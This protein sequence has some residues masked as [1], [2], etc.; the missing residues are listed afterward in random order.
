MSKWAAFRGKLLLENRDFNKKIGESGKEVQ[1]MAKTTEKEF[2]KTGESASDLAKNFAAIG[3]AAV[4]GGI[5][6][7]INRLKDLEAE[8]LQVQYAWTDMGEAGRKAVEKI[9]R[10]SSMLTGSATRDTAAVQIAL[11]NEGIRPDTPRG[12]AL[13]NV[14]SNFADATGRSH[15]STVD[16]LGASSIATGSA[17]GRL[18]D[19]FSAVSPRTRGGL[20]TGFD[21]LGQFLPALAP[22]GSALGLEDTDMA[23]LLGTASWHTPRPRRAGSGVRMILEEAVKPDSKFAK[24]FADTFNQSFIEAV[25]GRGLRGLID[26]FGKALTEWGDTGFIS[27]F[28]S[29]ETG[30]LAKSIVGDSGR[31]TQLIQAAEK[32]AGAAERINEQYA[33]T[34]KQTAGVLTATAENAV[35]SIGNTFEQDAKEWMRTITDI[36]GDE[37]ILEAASLFLESA[38]LLSEPLRQVAKPL[39][40]FAAAILQQLGRDIVGTASP[41]DMIITAIALRGGIAGGKK[42]VKQPT[43]VKTAGW[44]ALFARGASAVAKGG[45]KVGQVGTRVGGTAIGGMM[46]YN[47]LSQ[48]LATPED[49]EAAL[50]AAA[51]AELN[52]LANYALDNSGIV[53]NIMSDEDSHKF[54]QYMRILQKDTS[55]DGDPYTLGEKANVMRNMVDKVNAGDVVRIMQRAGISSSLPEFLGEQT[56]MSF[57]ELQ[58]AAER[59]TKNQELLGEMTDFTAYEM[60][61]M[62]RAA[63]QATTALKDLADAPPEPYVRPSMGMYQAAQLGM[64][65]LA[66]PGFSPRDAL[67]F[68][69]GVGKNQGM[70]Y[71]AQV[72]AADKLRAA[73]QQGGLNNQERGMLAAIDLHLSELKGLQRRTADATEGTEINTTPQRE[74][75]FYEAPILSTDRILTGG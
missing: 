45:S 39:A 15:G 19:I 71:L 2:K 66:P 75:A 35:L 68:V 17:H 55:L 52:V 25:E 67:K 57:E 13:T 48:M 73:F 20:R 21:L 3:G 16:L 53:K 9:N 63:G 11:S 69:G 26:A 8:L 31:L 12:L 37:D 49:Q 5:T 40:D 38:R 36:L 59:L 32:S 30:A 74:Y 27:S 61:E 43:N 29:A 28:G 34:L 65:Q 6:L 54:L 47:L 62:A 24:N 23:A 44:G 72:A 64:A 46:G 7:A 18:L 1:K 41:L 56:E 70:S 4:L 14:I 33:D 58:E 51:G 50:K 60:G 22:T 42:V 10:A